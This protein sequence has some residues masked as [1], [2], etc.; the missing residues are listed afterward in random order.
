[1]SP[2]LKAGQGISLTGVSKNRV[3]M[4]PLTV[5]QA[6]APSL[7]IDEI[8]VVVRQCPG[9]SGNQLPAEEIVHFPPVIPGVHH[10]C[11]I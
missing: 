11:S 7:R 2:G 3:S 4:A 9:A 10:P 1:M 8:A 5:M 6:V